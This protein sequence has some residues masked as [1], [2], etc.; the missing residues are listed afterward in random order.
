[1]RIGA[2]TVESNMEIPQKIKNGFAFWP[3]DPTSGNP[4]EGAQ[5]TNLKEHKHPCVHRGIIYNNQAMELAQVSIKD[6]QIKQLWDIYTMES[7]LE[8]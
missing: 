7:Y 6:E 8:Y 1:M 3:S 4:S 5:N 2:A